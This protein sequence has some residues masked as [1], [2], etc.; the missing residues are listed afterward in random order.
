[1][2]ATTEPAEPVDSPQG[3]GEFALDEAHLSTLGALKASLIPKKGGDLGVTPAI[4]G[5]V[6]LTIVF[7][8]FA[9]RFL[10]TANFANL[11]TQSTWVI[12]LGISVTFVLL[13]GEID[14]AAGY[15]AGVSVVT[16]AWMMAPPHNISAVVAIPTGFLIGALIGTVIG[17][18]VARIGIPGFVATL[19][20]FLGLQGVVL[21]IAR[22]GGTI[23]VRNE[24]II[25]IVNR[26][27]E[28]I[29]GWLLWAIVV[30]GYVVLALHRTRSRRAAGLNAEPIGSIAVKAAV[31][32]VGWGVA[33]YVLNQDRAFANAVRELQGVPWAVPL[34]VGVAVVL[35][36][37]L[38]RSAWGRHVYAVGGNIEAARR[39][40]INVRWVKM[41]CF[42]MTGVI[43]CVAGM[44]LASQLNSVS[45]Q[46]GGNDTLLRAVGAAA[47]GGVS[48]FGGRGKIIYP[49]VGGLV[50]AMIDNGLGLMG[51]VAGIDFTDSGPK[52]IV[53]GC[54][55]LVAAGVDAVSRNRRRGT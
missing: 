25:A 31:I 47:I 6:A 21:L 40:G 27:M 42:I 43:A 13:V 5:L 3:R 4:L 22:E 53:Q 23:S 8:V 34:L 33:T 55:L 10:S 1:M 14:L 39:A 44:A 24:L 49:V 54:V 46:T 41:S 26:N 45:P 7:G 30:A 2:A 38:T 50:V 16:M 32:A 17:F 15:T 52:F 29:L 28:P 12:L 18:L 36:L 11:I 35:H 9:E 48:L 37:V 51:T 20:F 19:A